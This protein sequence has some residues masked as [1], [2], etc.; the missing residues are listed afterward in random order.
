MESF[1]K[2]LLNMIPSIKFKTI[3]NNFQLQFKEDINK[4]RKSKNVFVFTDKTINLYE[5]TPEKYEKLLQE[6]VTKRY[7][8]ALQ[9]VESSINPE[10]KN[11]GKSYNIDD[12]VECLS[13]A[14]AFITLKD[15]KDNF[16]SH[17]TC[18]LLNLC[19]SE[20][21]KISKCILDEV[22]NTIKTTLNL[23][24]L[25]NTSKDIDWFINIDN[26]HQCTFI[27]LDIKEFEKQYID[28]TKRNI[29]SIKHCRK[30]LLFLNNEA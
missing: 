27:Q 7:K 10:A 16:R 24:Q 9:K 28:I 4:I 2:D 13:K 23:N 17:P 6:N 21:G 11:I 3:K 18:C 25:K 20:L 1:E 8:K 29:Q 19:K 30:S 15:H 5:M 26:K 14:E 12:R 22:N